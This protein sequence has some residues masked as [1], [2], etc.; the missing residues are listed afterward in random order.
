M[1]LRILEYDQTDAWYSWR[2]FARRQEMAEVKSSALSSASTHS[3]PYVVSS[4][5]GDQYDELESRKLTDGINPWI[6]TSC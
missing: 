3:K 6:V 2:G 5:L 1:I 4:D